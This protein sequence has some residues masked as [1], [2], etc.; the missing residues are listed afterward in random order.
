MTEKPHE[1]FA[2]KSQRYTRTNKRVKTR[3]KVRRV[4]HEVP[5]DTN[6]YSSGQ[7]MSSIKSNSRLDSQ[8]PLTVVGAAAAATT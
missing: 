5:N 3:M 8:S 2:L 6:G 7:F 4:C 1:V